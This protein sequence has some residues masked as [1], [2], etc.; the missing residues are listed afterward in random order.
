MATEGQAAENAALLTTVVSRGFKA[1]RCY[2][3][4]VPLSHRCEG[5]GGGDGALR[6][7]RR[8]R[9]TRRLALG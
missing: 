6:M 1:I 2:A 3:C 4:S 9:R 5:G 8:G 7:W